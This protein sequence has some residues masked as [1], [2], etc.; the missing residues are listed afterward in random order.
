MLFAQVS[1]DRFVTRYRVPVDKSH[2][3]TR[4][5]PSFHLSNWYTICS[6]LPLYKTDPNFTGCFGVLK[7]ASY[8]RAIMVGSCKK[9]APTSRVCKD[10]QEVPVIAAFRSHFY[11]TPFATLAKAKYPPPPKHHTTD[12]DSPS[13]ERK[14][15]LS[16]SSNAKRCTNILNSY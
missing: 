14:A 7:G 16:K 2:P 11:F 1:L 12:H 5:T 9:N 3:H 13:P 6:K 8:P 15:S 10:M 4:C